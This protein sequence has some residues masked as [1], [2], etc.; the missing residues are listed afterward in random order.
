MKTIVVAVSFALLFNT[1]LCAQIKTTPHVHAGEHVIFSFK[2]IKSGKY[3]TILESS[4]G[5]IL[6]RYGKPGKV[7]LQ[8]PQDP[9]SGKACFTFRWYMRPD[10]GDTNEGLDEFTLWFEHHGYRYEIAYS[11]Y[12]PK[13]EMSVH[14]S[15]HDPKGRQILFLEGDTATVVGSLSLLKDDERVIQKPW[16][17]E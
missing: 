1:A 15:V 10:V 14:L 9:V 13:K 16:Y 12:Y 3:V 2:A 7:E 5:D 11:Y 17:D 6:Y 8:F 4:S